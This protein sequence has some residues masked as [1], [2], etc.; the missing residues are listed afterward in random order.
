LVHNV[1][2]VT[3]NAAN[4]IFMKAFKQMQEPDDKIHDATPPFVVS[5]EDRL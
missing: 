2:V 3:G 1:L 5:E 4:I